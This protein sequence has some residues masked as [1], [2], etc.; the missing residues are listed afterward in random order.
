MR[1]GE[2][3]GGLGSLGRTVPPPVP[4]AALMRK[5]TTPESLPPP[6]PP[7]K[8]GMVIMEMESL[9]ETAAAGGGK[10]D[11]LK[12]RAAE[13]K[14]EAMRWA[15]SRPAAWKDEAVFTAKAFTP[16]ICDK[17]RKPPSNVYQ[18][19]VCMWRTFRQI[20]ALN[21]RASFV[22]DCLMLIAVGGVL[23]WMFGPGKGTN[24]WRQEAQKLPLRNFI[25]CLC[26]ALTTCL[27]ALGTF[28]NERPAFWRERNAGLSSF[29]YF[30]GKN[31]ADM[32]F[33]VIFPAAFML[34]FVSIAQPRGYSVDYYE[35]FFWVAW[36]A[37]GQGYLISVTN[38]PESA[39]FNGL[40]SVLMCVMFSGVEPPLSFFTGFARDILSLSFAR[41]AVESLTIL[42][43]KQYPE[44][45]GS[46]T[47]KIMEKHDWD[48]GNNPD[49]IKSLIV[50]GVVFRLFSFLMLKLGNRQKG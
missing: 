32:I 19:F 43:F 2:V 7:G 6:P 23:G 1:L 5:S 48:S 16:G 49:C 25:A 44:I 11:Q 39:K 13:A 28:G 10:M 15:K 17:Y 24:G 20:F 26:L 12:A 30:L 50:L 4:K 9:E 38:K 45:Y 35:T 41:W 47:N 21:K 31:V 33:V 34:M 40:L 42:E 46:Y 29:S 36:A 3:P 14:L 37:T 8:G 22:S 27:R 18:F